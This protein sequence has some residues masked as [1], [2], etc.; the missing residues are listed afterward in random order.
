MAKQLAQVLPTAVAALQ[1]QLTKDS[2]TLAEE[3]QRKRQFLQ[4][5]RRWEALFKR[6]DRGDVEA[7]KWL[8]ADYFKSLGHLSAEGLEA[9]TDELKARC[10]FFPTIKECLE[11]MNPPR[12][13]YANKFYGMKHLGE[14]SFLAAPE[15]P[16]HR[17]MAQVEAE[18]LLT[19]DKA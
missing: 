5:F 14:Q 1:E 2:A 19:S 15:K 16:N 8:I 10:T 13:D 17:L 3:N 18:R 12:F 11:I 9:L 6:A 7:E 4:V